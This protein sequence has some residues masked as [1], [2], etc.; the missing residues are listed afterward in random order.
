M[1]KSVAKY[2]QSE[3]LREDPDYVEYFIPKVNYT[4]TT[5]KN[6]DMVDGKELLLVNKDY[7]ASDNKYYIFLDKILPY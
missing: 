4:A 5:Y 3:G 7:D 1:H 2:A 6:T